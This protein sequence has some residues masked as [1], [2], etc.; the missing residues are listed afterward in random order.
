MS[1]ETAVQV[2]PLTGHVG[3]EIFGVNATEMTDETVAAIRAALLKYKVVFMRGQSL[4]YEDLVT[5]GSL[6]GELT[7]GHPI[8]KPP[9]NQPHVREMDSA[10]VGTRA[11]YWHTDLT[12]VAA[13]P[14]FA[15]LH[16]IVCPD[17][18]GDTIWAN[19]AAAYR[20]LPDDLRAM[21]DRMRIVHSNDSDY[22]SATYAHTPAARLEYIERDISAE[23][24]AVRVHPET[25]ERSLLLGGFARS[26]VGHRPRAG[27]ELISV[28]EE[29]ATQPEYT[30][31]WKWQVGD[32]VMWANQSTMHYAVYDYGQAHRRAIR[33]TVVGQPTVGI[34]G[35]PGSGS[36]NAGGGFD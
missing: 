30:V 4:E 13:P 21:A 10:G 36:T 20:D 2:R 34:D 25:G 28:L 23:H 33:V 32:L 35:V 7:P 16:N 12:F 8:Y 6:F 22:T 31:R 27:R 14:A 26:V 11:N 3:A 1:L 17:V 29:Y 15:I 19:T 9:A 5:Y 18:G 24:P